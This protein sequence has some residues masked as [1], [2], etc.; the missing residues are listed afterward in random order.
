MKKLVVF[1][2]LLLWP[3]MAARGESWV[4]DTPY[5]PICYVETFGDVLPERAEA[6]M[7][8]ETTYF[9]ADN[10][11]GW[12]FWGRMVFLATWKNWPWVQ[13]HGNVL[14]QILK[15]IMHKERISGRN[16]RENPAAWG[17][18]VGLL[19]KNWM[20]RLAPSIHGTNCA[21]VIQ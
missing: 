1:L 9:Y 21:L 2:L 5:N 20:L 18:T 8:G 14:R 17:C 16:L 13:K 15:R 3:A 4:V 7:A 11:H 10:L 12:I 6:A 19:R